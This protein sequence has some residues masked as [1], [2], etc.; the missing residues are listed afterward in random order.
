MVMRILLLSAV[1]LPATGAVLAAFLL[2][3][4][5]WAAMT[6]LVA[7]PVSSALLHLAHKRQLRRKENL[8]IRILSQASGGGR[9]AVQTQDA[10]PDRR[11]VVRRLAISIRKP[12]APRA[13]RLHVRTRQQCCAACGMQIGASNKVARCETNA[14]HKIHLECLALVKGRCPHCGNKIR[15]RALP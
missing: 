12:T 4:P 11:R 13:T 7:L 5:H 9:P 6:T 2:L 3:G 14:A 1:L 10:R 8:R 15:G